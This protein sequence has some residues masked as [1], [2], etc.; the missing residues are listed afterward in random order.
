MTYIP[1]ATLV[2]VQGTAQTG[3]P[4]YAALSVS[5]DGQH[6]GQTNELLY[7]I[8]QT[9]RAQSDAEEAGGVVEDDG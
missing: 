1:G 5:P 6:L 9:L 7:D 8:L 3:S 4:A 2:P